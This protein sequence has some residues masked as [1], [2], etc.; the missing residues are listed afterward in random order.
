M[1]VTLT[2]PNEIKKNDYIIVNNDLLLNFFN[3]VVFVA[4]KNGMHDTKG[5]AFSTPSVD[6]EIPK[7]KV[8][9]SKIHNIILNYFKI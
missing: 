7:E 6:L 2:Y 3:E 9:V 5:Y 8:H 4:I 1:F